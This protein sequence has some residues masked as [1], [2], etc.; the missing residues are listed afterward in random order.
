MNQVEA[1]KAAMKHR[2]VKP[3][4][5]AQKIGVSEP[6]FS[7]YL[8]ENVTNGNLR[9]ETLCKILDAIDYEIVIKPKD[10]KKDGAFA[11]RY[12]ASKAKK[13]GAE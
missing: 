10:S 3:V 4:Y 1:I 2:K 8:A 5:V 6:T 12:E 11:I 13:G 7:R 9:L